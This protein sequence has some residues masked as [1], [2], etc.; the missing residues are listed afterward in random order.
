MAEKSGSSGRASESAATEAATEARVA[1]NE[2]LASKL[3]EQAKSPSFT[4]D[5]LTGF[6][7]SILTNKCA[8]KKNSLP[9]CTDT[10]HHGCGCGSGTS[11]GFAADLIVLIDASADNK[12]SAS[13]VRDERPRR[14]QS[15]SN[16]STAN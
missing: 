10:G 8:G 2:G 3:I 14:P 7:N 15:D 5:A 1:A 13:N 16:T 6:V 11:A 9:P 4:C 12:T